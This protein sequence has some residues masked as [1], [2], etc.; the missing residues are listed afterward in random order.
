MNATIT[1]ADRARKNPFITGNPYTGTFRSQRVLGARAMFVAALV[2]VAAIIIAP[3]IRFLF[4]AHGLPARGPSGSCE[5]P[6]RDLHRAAPGA[7]STDKNVS[8]SEAFRRERT[9]APVPA[10]PVSRMGH[11]TDTRPA[12]RRCRSRRRRD[13]GSSG[14]DYS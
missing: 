9:L 5:S 2:V 12:C 10:D 3:S 14:R 13:S 8:A 11:A 6:A 7:R 1:R 4:R